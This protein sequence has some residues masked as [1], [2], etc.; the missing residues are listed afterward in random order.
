MN[1]V[2]LELV[3]NIVKAIWQE[4]GYPHR[5]HSLP[6]PKDIDA[7]VAPGIT[8]RLLTEAID[9][10]IEQ[11]PKEAIKNGLVVWFGELLC[12]KISGRMN[13]EHDIYVSCHGKAYQQEYDGHLTELPHGIVNSGSNRYWRYPLPWAEGRLT[14][15][16][17]QEVDNNSLAP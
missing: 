12:Y 17:R 16:S 15:M 3:P 10:Y 13:K 8:C 2:L 1:N 9:K 11:Y 14:E 7:T 5:E 4:Y 6:I